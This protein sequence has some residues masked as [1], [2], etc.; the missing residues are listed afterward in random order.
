MIL[1]TIK[2]LKII[3]SILAILVGAAC[4]AYVGYS[5]LAPAIELTFGYHFSTDGKTVDVMMTG[6]PADSTLCAVWYDEANQ[7]EQSCVHETGGAIQVKV[8][9]ATI[10]TT[11]FTLD[12]PGEWWPRK[13]SYKYN[14][15]YFC[16]L[17]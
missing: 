11:G 1:I 9:T 7:T 12:V 13:C 17:Q 14:H 2:Y 3:F 4:A 10:L 16:S 15:A 5:F 8:P 6:L